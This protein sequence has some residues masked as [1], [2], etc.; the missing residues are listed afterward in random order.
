MV[1]SGAVTSGSANEWETG[2]SSSRIQPL[3]ASEKHKYVLCSLAQVPAIASLG[4]IDVYLI[5]ERI[6]TCLLCVLMYL[7]GYLWL[8]LYRSVMPARLGRWYV[9]SPIPI[10]RSYISIPIFL[11]TATACANYRYSIEQPDTGT[12][13]HRYL[14]NAEDLRQN[15]NMWQESSVFQ[16]MHFQMYWHLRTRKTLGESIRKDCKVRE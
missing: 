14:C 9:L 2:S 5:C 15:Y 3:Y 8:S 7:H 10:F 13:H 1:G 6:S 16:L 4:S 11:Q 12:F